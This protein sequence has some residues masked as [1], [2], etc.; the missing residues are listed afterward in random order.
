MVC[1]AP[2]RIVPWAAAG[3]VQ[4]DM[5]RPTTNEMMAVLMMLRVKSALSVQL[6]GG[7]V[8]PAGFFLSVQRGM[9]SAP[10][11]VWP[12]SQARKSPTRQAVV[13]GP[14]FTGAG[15]RPERTQRQT[16][17]GLAGITGFGFSGPFTSW[18]RRSIAESG[19][20]SMGVMFAVAT[21]VVPGIWLLQKVVTG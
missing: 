16:L 17:A 21:V 4:D 10:Y 3:V 19:R 20:A 8:S 2:G 13:F 6:V 11:T 7:V 9:V 14:I 5:A 12:R 18:A 15:N 1:S